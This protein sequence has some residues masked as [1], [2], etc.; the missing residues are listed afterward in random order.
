MSISPTF[1]RAAKPSRRQL[2]DCWSRSVLSASAQLSRSELFGNRFTI[3]LTNSFRADKA[4][5][6][7]QKL[8]VLFQQAAT[9]AGRML[10][11]ELQKSVD[12]VP[13]DHGA[14][15]HPRQ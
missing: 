8:R 14:D 11:G 10:V 5:V 3:T 6:R 7:G 1:G 12:T 2:C 4:A 13:L 15:L 9:V